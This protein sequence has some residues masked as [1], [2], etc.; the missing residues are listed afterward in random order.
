[1][2]VR[3]CRAVSGDMYSNWKTVKMIGDAVQALHGVGMMYDNKQ[4]TRAEHLMIH[5]ALYRSAICFASLR[6]SHLPNFCAVKKAISPE[7]A[8]H[9]RTIILG[10]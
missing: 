5:G 9:S 6:S 2:M 3:E 10:G 4:K 8:R 7:T 1:M